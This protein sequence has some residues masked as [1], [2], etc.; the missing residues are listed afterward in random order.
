MSQCD[1]TPEQ[2]RGSNWDGYRAKVEAIQRALPAVGGVSLRKGSSNLFRSRRKRGARVDMSALNRVIAIYPD[3]ME[4]DVEALITYE[5]LVAE[6]LPHGWL[7]A[8]VPELKTITLGGAISGGGIESSSFR[9]GFVHETISEMDILVGTG[10]VVTVAPDGPH[11]DLY[12]G[13]PCTYGCLGYVL[14][15]R[16]RLIRAGSNVHLKHSHFTQW[17]LLVPLLNEVCS[18]GR[19]EGTPDFIDA[20][21]FGPDDSVLTTATMIS[22]SVPYRSDYSGQRIYYKS[23]IERREDYLSTAGYIW[24]WDTDWFWCARAFGVEVPI[25]RRLLGAFD[26]LNSGFYWR[27]RSFLGRSG[28]LR[29]VNCCKPREW[30]IQDVE[31]PI[32][33]AAEFIDFFIRDIGLFPFWVCPAQSPSDR[34]PERYPFTSYATDP[35]TLYLNF[36]FWGG[37]Q[38]KQTPS[39]HN[40]LIEAKVTELGGKK[41]LYSEAFYERREFDAIYGGEAYARLKDRYDPDRR[42]GDLFDKVV[43]LSD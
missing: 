26:L 1:S 21:V 31:I 34:H 42:M 2:R 16:I 41:S 23:L 19:A 28:L 20:V 3:A 33:R 6:L 24:R 13:F 22:G 25:I 43:R 18:K 11:A 35:D 5:R 29:A 32:N 15:A 17:R 7:P 37:V 40:R 38:Q 4:A 9:H 10:E 8:V 12:R 30:V 27:L 14:R 39:H 36:G